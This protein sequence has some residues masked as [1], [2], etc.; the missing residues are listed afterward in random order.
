M[1]K[2]NETN[3]DNSLYSWA[4]GKFASVAIGLAVGTFIY[5]SG[6]I[7]KTFGKLFKGDPSNQTNSNFSNSSR[8]QKETQE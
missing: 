4:T 3:N 8:N 6:I 1:T 7:Q 5:K 2:N